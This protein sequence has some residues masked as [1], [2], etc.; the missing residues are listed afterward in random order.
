MSLDCDHSFGDESCTNV[1][2]LISDYLT[3]DVCICFWEA[4]TEDNDQDR[5]ASTEPV[6]RSPSMRSGINETSSKCCGEKVSKSIT[7]LQHPRQKTTSLF[8]TVFEGCCGCVAIKTTHCDTEQSTTGE[9]LFV[10]VTEA[11]SELQDNEEDVVDDE[12]PFASISISS[13]TKSDGADGSEHE[14]KCDT[15]CDLYS[16]LAELLGKLVDSQTDSEEVKGI[17]SLGGQL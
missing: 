16:G 14:D 8:R 5:W 7:L 2:L 9:E 15:P 1:A 10:G 11:G 4:E 13:E 6:K 3:F 12:R 17:P